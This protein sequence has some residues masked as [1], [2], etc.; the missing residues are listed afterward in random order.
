M[1]IKLFIGMLK[2]KHFYDLNK[3]KYKYGDSICE[4]LE[5]LKEFYYKE[6]KLIDF[7][8]EKIVYTDNHTAVSL[9]TIK[10]LFFEQSQ[11]LA[12][13]STEE[14]I[15][16]TYA[17]ENI[18]L[19]RESVRNILKGFAPANEQENRILGLKKGFEF[20]SDVKNRINEENLYK[21]YMMC[22][23]DFLPEEDRLQTGYLYRH[24]SV[25]I[26]S[27]RVEHQGLDY[28]KISVYMEA[29][30]DF[31]NE[32]DSIGDLEK[33]CIIHFY[34]AYIHPY[35]DGNGR[36]AR[37]LHLWFLIQK[38]YQS[39]LFVPF[40]SEIEKS[41]KAYYNAFTLIEENRKISGKIDVTPIISYFT[42]NVYNK[43]SEISGIADTLEA[44]RYMLKDGRVTE[45]EK[46]LWTFVLSYYG[47]EEFS[48][49]MLERDFAD[50]AY[51]TIRDFVLKFE[52]SDLLVAVKYGNRVKY[53]VRR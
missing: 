25:F 6:I 36:I 31:I 46:K 51:A 4:F 23:G 18:D 44:Y 2:D 33:A 45:K 52:E 27:D 34:I 1:D 28:R 38:G 21:L 13:K 32:D 42:E 40:S 22:V 14:E 30:M 16:S 3:L 12:V 47:T 20:I 24:D 39:A 50:A 49:K 9:K 17:I 7:Y 37:L 41:R 53:R 26:V 8:G 5:N 29:L 43:F 11:K 48:T 10:Q 35:F 19:S 15:I